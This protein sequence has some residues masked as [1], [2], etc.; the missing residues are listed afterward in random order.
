MDNQKDIDQIGRINSI[1]EELDVICPIPY[2]QPTTADAIMNFGL[3]RMYADEGF[4]KFMTNQI[5]MEMKKSAMR[6][7]TLVDVAFAKA[8]ILTLQEILAKGK[9][10]FDEVS[11]LRKLQEDENENNG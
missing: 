1:I 5:N 9:V 8:R 3:A 4:R 11:K 6:T 2:T 10:A 7:V